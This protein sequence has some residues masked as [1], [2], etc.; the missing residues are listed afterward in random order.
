[1]KKL[2]IF[3]GLTITV[4]RC[5]SQ[6]PTNPF[7]IERILIAACSNNFPNN[8]EGLNEMVLFQLGPSAI[9][10]NNL[11]VKWA[12]TTIAWHGII[13][14]PLKTDS[15]N[16]TITNGCGLLL[17][18]P[19][20]IVPP[21][22]KVLLCTS[23]KI[24]VSANSFASL[25]DTAYII[26][27]NDTATTGHFKNYGTTP[28]LMRYF[29]MWVN[30]PTF[31]Q[32]SVAYDISLL[33]SSNGA[34][35]TYDF[36]G[37]PTYTNIGCNAPFSPH[38]AS[39]AIAASP[40]NA[41]C[42]GTSV[43]FTATPGYGG[44]T[45]SYQWLLNGTI[46]SGATSH[47]YTSSTLNNNNS[48]SCIMTSSS[49]C[50]AGSPAT[51]SATVMT[52]YTSPS[53][54]QPPVNQT[55]CNGA[56]TSFA[57]TANGSGLTYLWQMSSNGGTTWTNVVNSPPF[58]GATINTLNI[59]PADNS[60]NSDLF[61]CIISGTCAPPVTS[62]SALLTIN[63]PPSVTT[64]PSNAAACSGNSASFSMSAGGSA[65][66]YQWMV[67]TNGGTTWSNVPNSAPYNGAGLST[68]TINPVSAGMTGY[69]YHCIVSSSCTSITDTT[70]NATLTLNPT[71]TANAG[72]NAG[73]CPGASTI[74]G[75]SGG[76]LYAWSPSVGLSATNIFNPT[77][78]PSLTTTYT[79][80]VTNASGC[81]ASDN[82]I[83]TVNQTPT[84][85]AGN[86]IS[87]ANGT[88]T[89][90]TGSAS[91]GSGSYSYSWSPSSSLINA[92]IQ[93]PTT[94][95]LSSTTVYT[96]SVT[97]NVTGCISTDQVTIII[98][99]SALSANAYTN[100]TSICAGQNTQLSVVPSGGGGTYTYNWASNPAGF[101]STIA[102]PTA[103]PGGNT[104][105]L[106]TVSDGFNSVIAT[107]NVTV[108]PL[109]NASAGSDVTICSGGS[110]TLGASGGDTYNWSPSGGLN[111]SN[112]SNPIASPT[113]TTNYIVTVT[114]TQ[115]CTAMDAMTVT[116]N[117]IPNANAGSDTAICQGNSASLNASGGSSY[118]WSPSTSLSST[119]INNPIANPSASITYVVTVTNN[120]GCSDSDDI[121]VTVNPLPTANAGS[122]QT[123]CS[124]SSATLN[125][126]GGSSYIWNPSSSLN[127]AAIYNP[128]ANP[129]TTTIY[130]VTVTDANGCSASDFTTLTINPLPAANAGQDVFVCPGNS[131]GLL[132]SGGTSYSWSPSLGLN[133]TA[134]AN[135]LA[136]P[137]S[138][139]TY[140]VT[141]TDNNTCSNTDDVLVTV[142]PLPAA[143]AGND[144]SVC[145]SQSLL[146][147]ASGGTVYLWNTGASTSS[148]TVNP[149]SFSTYTVT[150]TNSNGCSA[151]DEV[152][153]TMNAPPLITLSADPGNQIYIGQNVTITASPSTYSNY[154]FSD[155]TILYNGPQNSFELNSINSKD[156]VYVIAS[157]NG[158]TSE[159]DTIII[160]IKQIPNAF[161]PLNND[162][163]N[164]VFLKGL[165]ITIFNRWGQLL[166]NGKDGWDGKYNGKYVS[167]GT[168][169]FIIKN[170]DLTG[171][172][173][174]IKGSVTISN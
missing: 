93:N 80:T 137:A 40:G 60:L 70:A 64:Q 107:T 73:I 76:T 92:N 14:A 49:P 58:S 129:S 48:I 118:S 135:P 55:V 108:N 7:E 159:P 140:I 103:S 82:V 6:V 106:V 146:L 83:V 75:A 173:T 23:Y 144:T 153:V 71:P 102:N 94:T 62:G 53:I 25:Q 91:G 47:I 21:H 157:Q 150:V 127:N 169:Y 46:I 117:P 74:L 132:A 100:P 61:H 37:N 18:P 13:G 145:Q 111:N 51:S 11:N 43:T 161:T 141:V 42:Q 69:L 164:D 5:Q 16:N 134:I 38:I 19:S 88:S 17:D 97:D 8:Y 125:A 9:N 24:Q 171:N 45:P 10:M 52:I 128:I 41:V 56:N 34:A 65:L 154:L 77:A 81:T 66:S 162:G 67:S 115:G 68:L 155:G 89:S 22:A 151:S 33:S 90:L 138:T 59:S 167:K 85:N 36:P 166:Y 15:L 142:F 31:Y 112:I 27:A 30:T 131:V 105:Y 98:T 3:I 123:I 124:G 2:L 170:N 26:Y 113:L 35:V 50:V 39:V 158:C 96:L 78:S 120:Q 72:N 32:D 119:I 109:P 139:T 86:D 84:A 172:N 156:T 79:V 110:T 54:I 29:K 130:T 1:M 116:V 12:T 114:S 87:I 28:P 174:E 163:V 143:F 63:P 4:L 148:I 122:D 121:T 44:T 20:G 136:S 99:G 104:T 152:N 149:S 160:E 126:S 101:G 147:T 168:Y 57:V 95:L 165:D 133:N